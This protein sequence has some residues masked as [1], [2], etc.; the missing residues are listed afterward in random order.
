MEWFINISGIIVSFL[1]PKVFW[2]FLDLCWGY[3]SINSENFGNKKIA[4]ALVFWAITR[5]LWVVVSPDMK[6][7]CFL[8]LRRGFTN[9]L[10]SQ[11]GH[12]TQRGVLWRAVHF[13]DI[14]KI[15]REPLH[16]IDEWILVVS[17]SPGYTALFLFLELF[18]GSI[19]LHSTV[20]SGRRHGLEWDLLTMYDV[21]YGRSM[22]RDRMVH[23]QT[24]SFSNC[25]RIG[26]LRKS[27]FI[28]DLIK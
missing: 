5:L 13:S 19:N 3:Y 20:F 17:L 9:K 14:K 12:F 16:R 24:R 8:N 1:I 22:D 7:P 26:I 10:F 28:W 21:S 27:L 4:S 18:I 2:N 11:A 6:K 25:R 15:P 23:Y